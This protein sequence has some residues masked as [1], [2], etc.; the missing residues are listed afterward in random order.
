[1]IR[2]ICAS[3]FLVV[4]IF[5]NSGKSWAYENF[6]SGRML[7]VIDGDTYQITSQIAPDGEPV[8]ARHFDTPEKG[9]RAACEAERV[10]ARQATEAAGRLLPRGAA[11]LLSDL[12]RDRYSRLLAA[13]SL[14]DGRDLAAVMIGA[15]LAVPYEGGKKLGWCQPFR[16]RHRDD[17]KK[18]LSAPRTVKGKCRAAPVIGGRDAPKIR[19]R[20]AARPSG[21]GSYP[22][23]PP[24]LDRAHPDFTTRKRFAPHFLR[25]NPMSDINNLIENLNTA[26]RAGD[27]ATAYR[28]FQRLSVDVARSVALKAGYSVIWEPKTAFFQHLQSQVALAVRNRT[29]G[30]G[31]RQESIRHYHSLLLLD[32]GI[33]RPE[34]GDYDKSTVEAER[35][36]YHQGGGYP[37]R[38]LRIITTS[39]TQSAINAAVATLNG[40]G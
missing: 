40:E 5:I 10:K 38:D 3:L 4:F 16:R 13:V 33:W 19:R 12:G 35:D 22:A 30:F 17:S 37:L 9:D 24:T 28:V 31:L 25:R 7:W 11:V 1:M 20:I 27:L 14:P 21:F 29:D 2:I 8:R 6:I 26:T 34:F 39:D 15:G 32:S 18:G 23:Q 36:D